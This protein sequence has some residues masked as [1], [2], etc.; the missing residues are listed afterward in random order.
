MDEDC[1]GIISLQEYYQTLETFGVRCEGG[2]P[3][4]KPKDPR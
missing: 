2:N 3:F 1:D 4:F